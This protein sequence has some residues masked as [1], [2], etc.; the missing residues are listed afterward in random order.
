MFLLTYALGW[1]DI[2]NN[3]MLTGNWFK[4]FFNSVKYYFGW[5]IPYWWLI[6]LIGALFI[7]LV[8]TIV[9][10][11]ISKLRSITKP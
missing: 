1:V 8:I 2:V 5:V 11:G 9:K 3:G 10:F 7:S 4:D 6:I